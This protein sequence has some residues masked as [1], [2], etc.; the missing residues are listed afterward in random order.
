MGQNADRLARIAEEILN[1]ARVQQDS[2][3]HQGQ[4]LPLDNLL[5]QIS[6]EWRMQAT[7]SRQ[8]LLRLNATARHIL[9]DEEH[10]RR[11]LINLL[12]NAQRHRS[13]A[14]DETGLRLISGHGPLNGRP[15]SRAAGRHLL[16]H[17]LGDGAPLDSSVERHL[18]EPFFSSQSRSSGLGLY[19]CRE[20]C[21]RY[22][23]SISYQRLSLHT[24]QGNVDG[25]AFIVT[26]RSG[27]AS[28]A[29]HT[30]FDSI[31]V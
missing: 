20:L 13:N 29:S 11:V 16:V 2:E 9:F 1:L 23:A 8:L 18:F 31:M 7:P 6:H 25:N 22:D 21:Q 19:I 17:G 12:D 3:T 27:P 15:G 28:L 4:S 14:G 24:P 30:L 5:A 10:L 26:L